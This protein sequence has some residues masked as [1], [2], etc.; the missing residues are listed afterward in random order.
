MG[1]IFT[2]SEVV[3]KQVPSVDGFTLAKQDIL[4]WSDEMIGAGIIEGT[5]LVGSSIRSPHRRG[6]IDILLSTSL[7]VSFEAFSAAKELR[8]RMVS[9]YGIVLDHRF[10]EE[11]LASGSMTPRLSFLMLST[12]PLQGNLRGEDPLRHGV[13][14]DT[15]V[16]SELAAFAVAH[17][18]Y[19]G[20]A[21]PYHNHR[22]ETNLLHSSLDAVKKFGGMVMAVRED[23]IA[24]DKASGFSYFRELL[25][26]AVAES[27][28]RVEELDRNYDA[29]L[30]ATLAGDIGEVEYVQYVRDAEISSR[31]STLDVFTFLV[32]QG[33]LDHLLE[34]PRISPEGVVKVSPMEKR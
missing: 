3:N 8:K 16:E 19:F 21:L 25:P 14:I 32:G 26:D 20:K 4:R 23:R 1:R 28:L 15:R 9:S 27:V 30:D 13:Q 6:D 22:R 31:I 24:T 5:R 12:E 18:L 33:N 11:E 10:W 34:R 7:P 17:R 29:V 2:W